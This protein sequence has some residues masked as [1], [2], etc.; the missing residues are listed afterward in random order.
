[1][2]R[3]LQI[4]SLSKEVFVFKTIV[5]T[6]L[7]LFISAIAFADNN[8]FIDLPYTP[9]GMNENSISTS[10]VPDSSANTAPDEFHGYEYWE[11]GDGGATIISNDQSGEVTTSEIKSSKSNI[12]DSVPVP[13]WRP[14]PPVAKAPQKKN[15]PA[16]TPQTTTIYDLSGCR[17][18]TVCWRNLSLT[19]KI[20]KIVANVDYVNQLHGSKIDP[21]YML[22][23]GWRESTFNPG[24]RGA[25]GEKGMFQVMAA[26]GRGALRYGPKL[27]GFKNMSSADYM[28]KMV[29]STLAQT[30]LSFLTLEMK[31]KEGASSRILSGG[32]SVADY[33]DLARRYNGSG[34]KAVHYSNKISS[35]FSC[36]REKIPNVHAST[37]NE[38]NTKSCLNRAKN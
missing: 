36:L 19:N 11:P 31:V 18:G 25:D 7:S 16:P 14:T 35:C 13:E 24:A 32:A 23:T 5:V 17:Y 1:L 34:S 8:V 9:P 38:G 15:Q 26:T 12:P 28:N 3:Q 37:I 27:P 29:N 22:C 4:L 21:R 20:K 6:S 10:S 2:E 33:K 30:E